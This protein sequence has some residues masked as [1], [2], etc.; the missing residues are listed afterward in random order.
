MTT[1]AECVQTVG[2]DI[3]VIPI[4]VED[5]T[6]VVELFTY[7]VGGQDVFIDCCEEHLH[8]ANY[9]V[10]VFDLFDDKSFSEC[11]NWLN[12]VMKSRKQTSDPPCGILIGNKDDMTLSTRV[13]QE[14]VERWAASNS[15]E[16]FQVSAVS[17][18]ERDRGGSLC[19]CA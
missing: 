8:D 2:V 18:L 3:S 10:V 1:T 14:E 12:L 5:S 11:R 16:Y 15:F 19:G 13:N 17:R 4:K 9:V 7:D 6:Q